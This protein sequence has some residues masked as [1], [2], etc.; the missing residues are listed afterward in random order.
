MRP[1]LPL[2]K[3]VAVS[4]GP[5]FRRSTTIDEGFK[6]FFREDLYQIGIRG[7]YTEFSTAADLNIVVPEARGQVGRSAS[8]WKRPSWRHGVRG[9]TGRTHSME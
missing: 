9:R 8:A 4:G 3:V 7:D 6:V 2:F 1:L 5:L